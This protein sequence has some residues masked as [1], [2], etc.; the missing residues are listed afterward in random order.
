MI[1]GSEDCLIFADPLVPFLETPTHTPEVGAIILGPRIGRFYDEHGD[2][3]DKPR[4]FP[5]HSI[6]LQMLGTFILW[7][8]W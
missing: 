2:V 8:G 4:H 7:F 3:L 5:A 1:V 6:S